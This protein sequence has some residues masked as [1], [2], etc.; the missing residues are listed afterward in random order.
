MA[1]RR[2][3]GFGA[4]EE[5]RC[6]ASSVQVWRP[7]SRT[8]SFYTSSSCVSFFFFFKVQIQMEAGNYEKWSDHGSQNREVRPRFARVL[9]FFFHRAVLEAKRTGKMNG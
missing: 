2:D 1:L 9:I 5:R 8:C 4:L 3:S 7:W 6:V